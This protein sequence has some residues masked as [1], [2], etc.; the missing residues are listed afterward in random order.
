MSHVEMMVM[1]DGKPVPLNRCSWL[2]VSPTGCVLGAVSADV[3]PGDDEAHSHFESVRQDR[4]RQLKWGFTME[5]ILLD[6][7]ETRARSCFTGKCGHE[8]PSD[9]KTCHSCRRIG[10]SG[11]RTVPDEHDKMRLRCLA[12]NACRKR[13]VHHYG[14]DERDCA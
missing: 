14:R 12:V 8:M 2:W 1:V 11:F 9:L 7:F 10:K 13:R 6:D 5:L 4:E 3:A